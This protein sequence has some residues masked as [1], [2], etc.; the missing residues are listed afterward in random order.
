[1]FRTKISA[2][3]GKRASYKKGFGTVEVI[4]ILAVL[5][6]LAMLFRGAIISYSNKLIDGVLDEKVPSVFSYD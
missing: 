2:F 6:A 1:M 3:A 5:I 4:L